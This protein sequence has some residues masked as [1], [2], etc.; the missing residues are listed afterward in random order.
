MSE[1]VDVHAGRALPLRV[2]PGTC[3]LFGR[4]MKTEDQK[5]KPGLAGS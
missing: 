5:E 2:P 1:R 4:V 3:T